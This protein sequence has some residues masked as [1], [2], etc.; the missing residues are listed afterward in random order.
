MRARMPRTLVG[1]M[2]LVACADPRPRGAAD[3][4][5]GG[6]NGAADSADSTSDTSDGTGC[7]PLAAQISASQT[8]GALPLAVRFEATVDCAAEG[9]VALRWDFGDGGAAEGPYA[10]HTW[11]GSGAA[12]VTLHATDAEGEQSSTELRIDVRPPECPEVEPIITVGALEHDELTEASGLVQGRTNPGLLWTHNDSGD[13][14]RVFAMDTDGN[15]RAIIELADAP[16]GD[17]EDIAI[18]E[19]PETG[20][21]LLFIGDIGANGGVRET[22][23]V[24]AVREPVVDTDELTATMSDWRTIEL[25]FPEGDAL[26]SDTLMVDPITGDLLLAA[27]EPDGRTGIFR[28]A[29]PLDFDATMA[30]QRVASIP[31]GEGALDGD[32]VPT[33]GEFSPLGDRIILR[34]D[35]RAWMWLRDQSEGIDAAWSADPCPMPIASEPQGEAIAFSWDGAGYFTVSEERFQP[36][37]YTPIVS[38]EPPCEGF[39]PRILASKV[40]GGIPFEPALSIDETCV[41]AGVA[42]VVWD[43]ADGSQPT[44]GST[45]SPIYLASGIIEVSAEVRDNTGAVVTATLELD[46]QPA[47]CPVPGETLAWGDVDSDEVNEAS[48]LGHSAANPGVLWTHNDSGDSARIF[49]MTEDGTHLGEFHISAPARDWEDLALGWDETIGGPAVYI[50]DI[51]DNPSSREDIRVVVVAEPSVSPTQAPVEAELDPAAVLELTYPDGAHNAE[52]LGLDPVTGD[53]II[54][55][56]DGSGATAVYRKPAPHI[57]A[58]STELEFVAE[59]QFGTAP[60]SGNSSTTGGDFSVLGDQIA[61][62]TYSDLYLW[63]RDQSDSLAETFATEP[64]DLEPPSERQGE[65]MTFTADGAGYVLVSEGQGQPISYTPLD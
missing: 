2:L 51:G 63:R 40:S 8:A 56:K 41:P 5:P 44:T 9:D 55:T 33:G 25:A 22:L 54:V 26:N 57:D 42:S 43:L 27:V 60:L 31:L 19:D 6:T 1:L 64:C 28:A 58:T 34:T 35:D 3:G 13:S 65:A 61:I 18:G 23:T 24:Y 29:A 53:L 20:E 21:P 52:M 15:H 39:E 49:A 14:P 50:G 12:T 38:P 7:G 46:V 59:L 45:I 10:N 32:S 62:R 11:L 37:Y 47:A 36:I 48:G 30:L 17:W 16:D 4:G